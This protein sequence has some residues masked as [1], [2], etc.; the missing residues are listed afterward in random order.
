MNL[1]HVPAG[2]MK[3]GD[4]YNFVAGLHSMQAIKVCRIYLQK[5][6]GRPP[7]KTKEHFLSSSV[8]I[9]SIDSFAPTRAA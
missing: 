8:Q 1:Q 7:Y 4:D 6:I 2:A 9:E 5:G 3:P